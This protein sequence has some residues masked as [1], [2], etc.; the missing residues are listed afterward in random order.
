M[1][2]APPGAGQPCS[3]TWAWSAADAPPLDGTTDPLMPDEPARVEILRLHLRGRPTHDGVDLSKLARKTNEFSGA[4]L[5]DLVE[6]ATEAPLRDALRSGEIRPL[7]DQDFAAALKVAR[8]STREW[9]A[10]AKNYATFSNTGGLYD[11]LLA[12]LK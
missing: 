12:Y 2:W 6:R 11:D 9:F 1:G 8:P 10:T 5:F 4:D 7:T 3:T